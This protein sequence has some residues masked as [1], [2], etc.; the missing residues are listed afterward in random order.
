[1]ICHQPQS[2]ELLFLLISC[3]FDHS[4][5][6]GMVLMIPAFLMIGSSDA[7]SSV[8]FYFGLTLYSISS[9]IIVPCLTTLASKT[10]S[11][12]E[13]KGITLGIFRSIGALARASGP[14]AASTL[15]WKFGSTICYMTGA[16]LLIYPL[17]KLHYLRQLLLNRHPIDCKCTKKHK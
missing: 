9:G 15:F 11:E 12:K 6:Q 8:R 7:G 14:I 3:I 2:C 13:Q 5:L 1:M 10:G 16:S 4:W 17:L